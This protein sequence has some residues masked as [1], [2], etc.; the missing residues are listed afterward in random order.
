MG[1][2][3]EMMDYEARIEKLE[4]RIE[5]LEK[6]SLPKRPPK[7]KRERFIKLDRKPVLASMAEKGWKP[8]DLAG[9]IWGYKRDK[10]GKRTAIGK[11]RI[12][13]WLSGKERVSRKNFDLLGQFVD[14]V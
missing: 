4:A 1:G 10:Q 9:Q 12:S 11:D 7:Q 2:F 8:S 14:L 5:R 3:V 6:L 13:V